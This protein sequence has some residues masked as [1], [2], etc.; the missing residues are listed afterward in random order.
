MRGMTPA[1]FQLF[2]HYN[3][4]ANQRLYTAAATLSATVLAEE[5]PA[6]FFRS[7]LG[8]LNHLVVADRIWFA[9][10]EGG[11]P[12]HTRL[13]DEPFPRFCDLR[14][15][16]QAE[17]ERILSY[18]LALTDER[19]QRELRY[20]TTRGVAQCQPLWQV[21]AH[22]FNHQ[23]HHRGQAH[24]LM[25]DAGIVPPELDLLLY[26]RESAKVT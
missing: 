10:I 18:T 16:R 11:G 20:S 12:T 1:H 17:D 13:N 14:A 22:V 4:W 8:T 7:I 21:L 15:V 6:A 2:G 24:A 19:L 9:R 5:R 3:T 26:L 25:K 23:T